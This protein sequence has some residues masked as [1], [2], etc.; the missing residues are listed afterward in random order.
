VNVRAGPLASLPLTG[1]PAGFFWSPQPAR[2]SPAA[3]MTAHSLR[4][5]MTLS[6]S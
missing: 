5:T 4:F 3:M 2:A 1:A 6:L